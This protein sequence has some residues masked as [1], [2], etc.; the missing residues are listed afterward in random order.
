MAVDADRVRRDW[1]ARGFGCDTWV[2]APGGRWEDF[3]HATDELVVVIEGSME[4]EI[5]GKLHHPAP[6]EELFI[7]AGSVHSAR[8]IGDTTARWLYG[9]RRK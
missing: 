8:N 5:E 9:Y 7:P 3:V 2:D 1:R 6:G 4:F